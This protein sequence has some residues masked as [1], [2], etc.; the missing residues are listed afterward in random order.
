MNKLTKIE[1]CM[2]ISIFVMLLIG[3]TTQYKQDHFFDKHKIV[4]CDY[5]LDKCVYGIKALAPSINN[6][7]CLEKEHTDCI[8]PWDKKCHTGNYMTCSWEEK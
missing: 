6:F 5:N 2:I 7:F 3:F 4:N 1:I 8:I